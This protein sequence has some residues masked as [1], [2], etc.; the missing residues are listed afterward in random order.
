VVLTTNTIP[1]LFAR[2]G[3]PTAV[4]EMP[5]LVRGLQSGTVG[6]ARMASADAGSLRETRI[7]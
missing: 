6:A 1:F 3:R 5:R 4:P 2:R 7:K